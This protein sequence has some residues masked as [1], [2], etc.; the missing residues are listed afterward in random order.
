MRRVD[1]EA[2]RNR[3]LWIVQ[4]GIPVITLVTMVALNPQVQEGAKKGVDWLR[5]KF[6]KNKDKDKK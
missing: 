6:G 1:V 2:S 3:R 5:N 4:V